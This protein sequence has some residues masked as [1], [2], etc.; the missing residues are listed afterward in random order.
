MRDACV[1]LAGL[2]TLVLASTASPSV[3]ADDAEAIATCM[4]TA[5]DAGSDVRTCVGRVADPCLERP[6]GQSTV[7]MVQCTDKEIKI[8]DEMLN[9]EYGRLLSVLKEKA[10]DDVRKAQRLWIQS[11][12]ADCKV[13]YEIFEGGTI[14]Q[15]IGARCMLDQ[16][17]DRALQVRS[18]REMA[19]PDQ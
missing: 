1:I 14:A 4:Q 16:T 6:E 8:W 2:V 13:P 5:R 9:E 18:W 15:P 12:D 11:R 19:Q 17:A 3:R 7:G 10:A